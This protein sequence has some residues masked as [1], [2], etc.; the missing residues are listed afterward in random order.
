[1]STFWGKMFSILSFLFSP[2]STIR[3]LASLTNG[4][5]DEAEFLSLCKE[6]LKAHFPSL[7]LD[8]KLVS[9]FFA[10]RH[11]K[12]APLCAI[13]GGIV[14]QVQFVLWYI[15]YMICLIWLSLTRQE[16]VKGLSGKFRPLD[17]WLYLDALEL[18]AGP[19]TEPEMVPVERYNGQTAALGLA[20]QERLATARV[21][22][23]GAGVCECRYDE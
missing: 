23:V 3:A 1:M 21:F 10:S 12:L 5:D 2:T 8:E 18:L 15:L 20:L 7:T 17:Q 9:D 16:A 4:L 19:P 14:A 13:F 22:V 6:V 11:A